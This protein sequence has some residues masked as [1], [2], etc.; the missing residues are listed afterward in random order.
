MEMTYAPIIS[1]FFL[2]TI[3]PGII[4]RILH[5]CTF[6][7]RPLVSPDTWQSLRENYYESR[8]KARG[9][10]WNRAL[11]S[12]NSMQAPYCTSQ[13]WPCKP[14]GSVGRSERRPELCSRKSIKGFRSHI[15]KG[16]CRHG[17]ECSVLLCSLTLLE[18][19]S[20]LLSKNNRDLVYIH[21]L[22]SFFTFR[23]TVEAHAS[24]FYIRAWKIFI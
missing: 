16:L 7:M 6:P 19:R 11:K 13:N 20:W 24:I 22:S 14:L 17:P 8:I 4:P 2:A 23:P 1:V 12:L 18:T 15:T 9:A 21:K 5:R 3:F 10:A